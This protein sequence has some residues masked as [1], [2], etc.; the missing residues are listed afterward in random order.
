MQV[1][2]QDLLSICGGIESHWPFNKQSRDWPMSTTTD[3]SLIVKFGN[4]SGF[5][6]SDPFHSSVI[7][8]VCACIHPI[9]YPIKMFNKNSKLSV[10]M[11]GQ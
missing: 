1:F 8:V 2:G 4:E 7:F 9:G 10:G 5:L 3:T 11:L 6:N